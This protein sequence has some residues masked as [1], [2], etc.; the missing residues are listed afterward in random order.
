MRRQLI[1][2]AACTAAAVAALAGCGG[3]K[4][5]KPAIGAPVAPAD[6]A[7]LVQTMGQAVYW[8]GPQ[9]SAK[10][11]LTRGT[12]GRVY[13]QY[14][15]QS[16]KAGP[17]GT[18][19]VGTYRVPTPYTALKRAA[20]EPGAKSYGIAGGR[21]LVNSA[22]PNNAYLAYVTGAYQIEVYDPT[23]GRAL[24]LVR[25]G[26]VKPAPGSPPG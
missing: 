2:L 1:I 25:S 18:L 4:S 22:H 24:D 8:V 3:S 16:G 6:L 23:P 11:K 15:P 21:V 9:G 20:H 12:V 17:N 7:P 19:T 14:L 13:V 26:Q 5:A 10:F